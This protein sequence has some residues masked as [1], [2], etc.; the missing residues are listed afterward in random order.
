MS[1]ILKDVKDFLGV[2]DVMSAWAAIENLKIQKGAQQAQLELERMKNQN[3]LI[4]MQRQGQ[5]ETWAMQ[6]QLGLGSG[7]NNMLWIAFGLVALAGVAF[8]ALRK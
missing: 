8:V 5:L 6:Q 1:E 3:A 7:S 2:T 4:E